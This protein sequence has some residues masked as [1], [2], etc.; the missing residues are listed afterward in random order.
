VLAGVHVYSRA[1]IIQL[2]AYQLYI[3]HG[4]MAEA[5][6]SQYVM[7]VR[8]Q[9][10]FEILLFVIILFNFSISLLGSHFIFEYF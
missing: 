3:E 4:R 10:R 6:E 2:A 7:T 5:N 9:F 1:V 8:C